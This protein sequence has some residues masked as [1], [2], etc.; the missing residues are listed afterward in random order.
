VKLVGI[1][2]LLFGGAI[3]VAAIALLPAPAARACFVAAGIALELLG[4]TLL[5]RDYAHD[6]KK[7]LG[8]RNTR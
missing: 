6:A 3:A 7:A 2:F 8:P 4:L 5:A 1:L